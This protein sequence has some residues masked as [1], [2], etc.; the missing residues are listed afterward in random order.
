M[1]MAPQRGAQPRSSCAEYVDLG[2]PWP[3]TSDVQRLPGN[4]D[5]SRNG[6]KMQ[7]SLSGRCAHPSPFTGIDRGSL[8]SVRVWRRRS[9][10][11]WAS[12]ELLRVQHDSPVG[13]AVGEGPVGVL[14]GCE[15]VSCG[16]GD[17]KIAGSGEVSQPGQ[18]GK[19]AGI[20]RP[21]SARRS[22]FRPC[23]KHVRRRSRADHHRPA[24]TPARGWRHDR[25]GGHSSGHGTTTRCADP[26][27][28]AD[29][30][31]VARPRDRP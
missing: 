12:R 11:G 30:G 21:D 20:G 25:D 26:S 10:M 2:Q 17:V 1:A 4:P 8:R 19:A 5:G 6:G 28:A 22:R 24:D 16:D 31:R 18:R 9:I 15:W 14:H 27:R 23:R 13:L 3:G 29:A 7:R